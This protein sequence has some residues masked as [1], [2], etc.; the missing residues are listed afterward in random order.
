M[1]APP[2][3]DWAELR[4]AAAAMTSRS[5]APYSGV[6]VGAAGLVDDGRLVAG[7]NVENASYGLGLCA[8]CGLVSA[9]FGSGGGRLVAVSVVAGDGQPLVAVRS[10][11]PATVRGRRPGAAGGR[12]GRP[13]DARVAAARRLRSRRR[14]PPPQRPERRAIAGAVA[15]DA[16][17]VI[18]TKRDGGRLTAEQIEWFI[19]GYT[20]GRVADEQAAALL[21]AIVF[22]GLDP[23]EL[24]TLDR[25]H[26]RLR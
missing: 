25:S 4:A 9:L 23:D 22:R 20:D 24:A 21:M 6:R 3:V 26:D 16:L 13:A 8:E 15:T 10:V 17:D 1:T 5:Y 2:L 7:C 14:G 12:P 19:T 11:P 18:R